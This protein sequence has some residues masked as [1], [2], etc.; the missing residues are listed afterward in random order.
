MTFPKSKNKRLIQSVLTALFIAISVTPVLAAPAL[1]KAAAV[2]HLDEQGQAGYRTFL[3]QENH[4]AF[5]IAPGGGWAWRAG[6]SSTTAATDAALEDCAEQNKACVP[7]AVDQQVVFDGKTWPTLWRP[8][9]SKAEAARAREGVSRGLRFPDLRL[10]DANGRALTLSNW[11]SEVVVLHFW[12]SWC[13]PCRRELPDLHKLQQ[14]LKNP[15]GIRLVT[16]QVREPVSSARGWLAERKLSLPLYDSG[17]VDEGEQSMR[18]A[19]GRV[20]SDRSL[21]PVFPTTYVL[22]RQGIVVFAHMGPLHQWPQY[23]PF[24]KDVAAFSEHK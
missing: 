3:Q 21:A 18:L 8:Y 19:D 13:P 17:A 9:L 7:Y 1:E 22:D 10:K 16:I 6:M 5:V 2:P 15:R 12:G 20:I 24:L 11:R 23:L 14:R 4:R